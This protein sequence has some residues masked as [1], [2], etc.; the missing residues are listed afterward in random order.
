MEK[1]FRYKK[2]LVSFLVAASFAV[3][4]QTS[5][6]P[7]VMTVAGKDVP[8]SEFV[9]IAGKTSEVN[10]SDSA[11]LC[12]YLELFKKFKLKV[13]EAESFGIDTTRSFADELKGYR[14]QLAK[15]YLKDSQIVSEHAIKSLELSYPEFKYLM[16]EYR[17]GILLFEVSNR[18]VWNRASADKEG[19][20]AFFEQHK[21]QYDAV[22]LEPVRGQV[23]ADYQTWLDNQ[24]TELLAKKYSIKVYWD[25]LKNVSK[26]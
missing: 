17:D 16:Q 5:V 13:A 15:S 3:K 20:Q 10:L 24:W 26:R 4:A 23:I 8:L 12:S 18:E 14:E 9:Y 25:V 6:D 21:A 2:L 19:L 7:V 22:T 11:S 1:R